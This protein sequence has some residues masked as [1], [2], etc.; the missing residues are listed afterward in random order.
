MKGFFANFDNAEFPVFGRRESQVKPVTGFV[1]DDEPLEQILYGDET[2]VPTSA[3][4]YL[5]ALKY[6][7]GITHELMGRNIDAAAKKAS[8]L[9]EK[10]Y[11]ITPEMC[12]ELALNIRQVVPSIPNPIMKWDLSGLGNLI[13]ITWGAAFQSEDET[14]Q[15]DVGL[16]LFRWYEHYQRYEKARNVLKK[17]ISIYR[18]RGDRIDEAIFINNLAFEYLLEKRFQEAAPLFK[19]AA[20]MFGEQGYI[21]ERAN[22]RANYLEC[23]FGCGEF[24]DLEAI[25]KEMIS[26]ISILCTGD[27]WKIRKPLILFARIQERKGNRTKAITLVERAIK[28][29]EHGNTRYSEMDTEYLEHLRSTRNELC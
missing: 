23:I 12:S 22:S 8:E 4:L 28:V 6:V 25:E 26:L 21:F 19:K 13:D 20:D 3:N 17:L 2:D 16:S 11:S 15:E 5:P 18:K 7:R 10:G 27:A 24:E 9:K 14:V 29:C 1:F